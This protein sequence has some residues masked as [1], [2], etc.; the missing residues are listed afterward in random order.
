MHV[1]WRYRSLPLHRAL[2]AGFSLMLP[3]RR[4]PR[5]LY[6]PACH[7]FSRLPA[8][9]PKQLSC[10]ARFA[11]VSLSFL[12]RLRFRA[13]SSAGILPDMARGRPA[14]P[15][16]AAARHFAYIIS[17]DAR[18]DISISPGQRF[19]AMMP[20]LLAG[21][22]P[23]CIWL[24][25]AAAAL[26][27]R[28]PRGGATSPRWQARLLLRIRITSIWPA[29]ATTHLMHAEIIYAHFFAMRRRG[30]CR[31]E[32]LALRILARHGFLR[33]AAYDTMPISLPRCGCRPFRVSAWHGFPRC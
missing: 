3:T 24:S 13:A 9:F 23:S 15:P 10:A 30:P 26:H 31:R 18:H 27:F 4:S 7:Y 8:T 6:L 16:F 17:A 33:P 28:A 14:W 19:A 22:R 32:A 5:L 29:F 20:P 1:Y 11:L 12:L 2:A 21:G 25:I